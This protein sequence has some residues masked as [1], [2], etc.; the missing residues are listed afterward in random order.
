[1]K[2][3]QIGKVSYSSAAKSVLSDAHDDHA[4]ERPVRITI[5]IKREVD[6]NFISELTVRL[7]SRMVDTDVHR[8][9]QPGVDH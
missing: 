6:R 1:M 7:A 2:L 5:M 4:R 3:L 8:E 9:R